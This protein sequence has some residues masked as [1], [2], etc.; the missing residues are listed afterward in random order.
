MFFLHQEDVDIRAFALK[1][2]GS[3]CIRHYEFMLEN[4]LKQVYHKLL[5]GEDAPLNMKSE[6]LIN[7]EMYLLEEEK[8]MVQQDL[9]CKLHFL[10]RYFLLPLC[11]EKCSLKLFLF[12][13]YFSE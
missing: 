1:A 4:D 5:T 3:I 12:F 7:I 6:V 10:H 11:F 9:E 2:M 13:I 8:R